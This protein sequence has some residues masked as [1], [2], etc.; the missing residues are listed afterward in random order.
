MVRRP[1]LYGTALHIVDVSEPITYLPWG[2]HPTGERVF[3][4]GRISAYLPL[5]YG[6][7]PF[8]RTRLRRPSAHRV[9]MDAK[10][11]AGSASQDSYEKVAQEVA[12]TT[13]GVLPGGPACDRKTVNENQ[14]NARRRHQSRT[15]SIKRSKRELRPCQSSARTLHRQ[16]PAGAALPA[17]AAGP[18][19]RP[20]LHVRA[21]GE[22]VV[23]KHTG[24]SSKV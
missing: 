11:A 20:R 6:R 5:P 1:L 17:D 12:L 16:C 24:K 2:Q 15:N 21:L 18:G 7:A 3:T 4:S 9:Q 8:V 10:E 14:G 13:P 22:R 23:L 19:W